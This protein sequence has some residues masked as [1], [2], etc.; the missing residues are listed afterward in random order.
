MSKVKGTPVVFIDGVG[1]YKPGE[2]PPDGYMDRIEW[3]RVQQRAG[4]R[5]SRCPKCGHWVYQQQRT[6]DGCACCEKVGAE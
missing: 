3:H 6:A 4:L 2:L 1:E 5:Q